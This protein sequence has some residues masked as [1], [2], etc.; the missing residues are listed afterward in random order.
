MGDYYHNIPP[1]H[2][3]RRS[4]NEGYDYQY[5]M[6]SHTPAY[7]PEDYQSGYFPPP[8]TAPQYAYPPSMQRR[9]LEP[10]PS[11]RENPPKERPCRVLFIR[12]IRFG[13]TEQ[14]IRE[15]FGQ[16]G[17]IKNIYNLL[18]NRGIAFLTFFDLRSAEKAKNALQNY[19]FNGRKIDVHFSLPKDGEVEKVSCDETKDQGTLLLTVKNPSKDISTKDVEQLMSAF[20][21]VKCIRD[22]KK[23]IK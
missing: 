6:R 23:S 19:E 13:V 2:S 3:R 18:E 21:D 8:S 10:V 15:L 17:D 4:T 12:N 9:S 11:V 20:G 22:Y 5:R 14:Q 1:R 16:Y 7:Y